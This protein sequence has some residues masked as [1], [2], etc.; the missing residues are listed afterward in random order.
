MH[1]RVRVQ[2]PEAHAC[3]QKAC[4]FIVQWRKLGQLENHQMIVVPESEALTVDQG[5]ISSLL[6]LLVEVLPQSVLVHAL[7]RK[8]HTVAEGVG[9]PLLVEPPEKIALDHIG[10]WGVLLGVF[11]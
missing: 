2:P 6:D 11:G 4:L 8:D 5:E 1:I 3:L 9:R 10:V 7:V